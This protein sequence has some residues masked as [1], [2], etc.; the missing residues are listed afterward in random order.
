MKQIYHLEYKTIKKNRYVL[1]TTLA[2]LII[3]AQDI[4]VSRS[5]L[6]QWDWEKPFENDVVIIR[7]LELLQHAHTKCRIKPSL[8]PKTTDNA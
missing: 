1:S 6:Y 8:N 7:K 3:H 4:D 5:T 2:Q